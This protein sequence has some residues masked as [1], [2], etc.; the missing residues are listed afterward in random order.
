VRGSKVTRLYLHSNRIAKFTERARLLYDADAIY[1]AHCHQSE[2]A[3]SDKT[4][5]EGGSADNKSD[6]PAAI[7]EEAEPAL[8]SKLGSGPGQRHGQ[9]KP[10]GQSFKLAI[11]RGGYTLAG[12]GR[13]KRLA[14]RKN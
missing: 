11:V 12:T 9:F 7:E 5:A 2:I 13:L 8:F 6:T 10:I 14:P 3:A 4:N 1:L